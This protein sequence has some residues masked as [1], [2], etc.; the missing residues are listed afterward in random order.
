MPSL[1][2]AKWKSNAERHIEIWNLPHCIHAVDEKFI[3]VKCFPKIGSPCF[4]YKGYFS[5]VLLARADADV[6]FTTVHVGY[7]GK[8]SDG[9]V[10]RASRLGHAGPEDLHTL[11]PASVPKDESGE[12]F[13]YYFV[14]G[15]A[16]PLKVN[17]MRLYPRRMLTNKKT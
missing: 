11:C 9:S 14:A 15:E 10:F 1:N 16:F 13:P 6:L 5:A 4:N 17:V 7:F 2:E 12:I 3:C 8:N